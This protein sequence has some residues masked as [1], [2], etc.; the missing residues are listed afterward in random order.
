MKKSYFA[1]ISA[2]GLALGL[3]MVMSGWTGQYAAAPAA[4]EKPQAAPY[5]A[6]S[7]GPWNAEVAKVHVPEVSFKKVGAE[8]EVTV[9]VDS[10]PMDPQK[11]HYIMWI[12]LE[13]ENGKKLAEH[14]FKPTDPAPVATFKLAAVPAKIKALEHCN[15]HGTWL[16]EAAV[17]MK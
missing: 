1:W 7:F 13:D 6:T 9:K 5:T 2:V 16:N 12:R 15:I 17:E 3:L 11:P 8:T 14:E 10:H 4:Q